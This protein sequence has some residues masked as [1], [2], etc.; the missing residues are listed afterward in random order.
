MLDKVALSLVVATLLPGIAAAAPS[1]ATR[2]AAKIPANLMS[3]FAGHSRFSRFNHLAADTKALIAAAKQDSDDRMRS[4]PTFN[5][6]FQFQG[7]TFPFTMV[8]NNPR[9]GGEVDVDTSYVAL[10]FV[11]DEFVDA[12]GNNVFIDGTSIV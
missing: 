8:G 4:F 11:F 9:R 7:T 3:R 6:S 12:N 10:S 1:A 2:P 5:S